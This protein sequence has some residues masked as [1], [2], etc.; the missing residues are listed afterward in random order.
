MLPS[1]RSLNLANAACAAVYEAIR[2]L[3]ESGDACID[4]DARLVPRAGQPH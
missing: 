3:V 4:D 1:E 2:Q